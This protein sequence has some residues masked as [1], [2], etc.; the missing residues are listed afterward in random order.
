MFKKTTNFLV[1]WFV[2]LTFAVTR[3]LGQTAACRVHVELT[4]ASLLAHWLVVWFHWSTANFR[5]KRAASI[6]TAVYLGNNGPWFERYDSQ[7]AVTIV[8]SRFCTWTADSTSTL[9]FQK[10]PNPDYFKWHAWNLCKMCNTCTLLNAAPEGLVFS[11][12]STVVCFFSWF[13]TMV[14]VV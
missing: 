2:L 13:L 11:S 8:A 7:P 10:Q 9:R 3:T 4:G 1:I 12:D 5:N 14:Q 6:T